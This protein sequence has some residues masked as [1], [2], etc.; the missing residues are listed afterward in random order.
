MNHL[1][2]VLP[3]FTGNVREWQST[4]VRVVL[5]SVTWTLATDNS[6]VLA[7]QAKSKHP[8]LPEGADRRTL[9]RVLSYQGRSLVTSLQPLKTWAGSVP[10]DLVFDVEDRREGS[11]FG[12][13]FDLGRLAFLLLPFT[14]D[15][16][17]QIWDGRPATHERS[18]L[19]GGATWRI[20]LMALDKPFEKDRATTYPHAKIA[21][22]S[23]FELAM[24]V[25]DDDPITPTT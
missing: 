20:A 13:A 10:E 15:E 1:L 11:F 12:C 22:Q 24:T 3:Q 18:L 2:S 14:N 25:E 4:P 5:G 7:T 9:E 17:V 19:L 16:E 23:L 8:L 21:M 6:M